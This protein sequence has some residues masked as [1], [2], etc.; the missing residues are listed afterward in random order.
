VSNQKLLYKRHPRSRSSARDVNPTILEAGLSDRA[1]VMLVGNTAETVERVKNVEENEKK[2]EAIM[3]AR[4]AKG[5]TK[6]HSTG[7]SSSSSPSLQF[8]FHQIKPLEHLPNPTEANSVLTRLANDPGILH[9][10]QKHRYS[11]GVLTELAPH[12]HPELLGLNTNKGQ[13]ISLR[14]RTNAY[15]GFRLYSEVRKVLVHELTHCVWGDHDDNFKKLNSQHSKEVLEFERAQHTGAH[16]L[17]GISGD[18]Y[19]PQSGSSIGS[20]SAGTHSQVLGGGG[21]RLGGEGTLTRE[22]RRARILDATTRRLQLEEKDI[23]EMCGNADA[24]GSS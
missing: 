22:E 8:R 5:P 19:D 6:L 13:I 23:E 14:I 15:D 24:G 10:M 7:F 12:E 2:R 21:R 11:V 3:K 17:S 1:R 20:G 16:S 4:E 18:V 9:V